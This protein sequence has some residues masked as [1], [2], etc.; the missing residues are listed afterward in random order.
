MIGA[1][2]AAN[3]FTGSALGFALA[4]LD[5]DGDG[6]DDLAIG[7]VVGG[8]AGSGNGGVAILY[9][10][11][12][13][14]SP[15]LLSDTDASGMAGAVVRLLDDP[16]GIPFDL[17]GQYLFNVGPTLGG[18]DL[19]DDLA[20]SYADGTPSVYVYR[21]T[22][23]RPVG[24]GVHPRSFT[25]GQDV[26]FDFITIDATVEMGAAVGSIS[27]LNGDGARDLVIG[28]P[29]EGSSTGRVLIVDGNAVGTAGVAAT[30]APGVVITN[31]T[32]AV[33]GTFLGTAVVNNAVSGGSDVDGDGLEDLLLTGKTGGIVNMYVWFGGA[34][35]LGATTTATAGHVVAGPA[36]FTGNAPTN[37]G[38]N[39]AAIW[40][41][42]VNGDGLSD[43]CWGDAVGNGLDGSF[44]VLWDDGN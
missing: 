29:K 35:P 4:A 25:V 3:Y 42:D 15:I 34:I 19:T 7:A 41:G 18:S 1:A 14:G 16:N 13:T 26:R 24:A 23:T 32:P 20:I 36:T 31:I 40:A 22:G 21:G 5:Y 27:D 33:G 6:N 9:G 38:T 10:G 37:G 8:F 12:A 43:V 2:T 11:T 28:M 44:Q 39:V 17:F 30:N